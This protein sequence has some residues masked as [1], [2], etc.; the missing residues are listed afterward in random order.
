[1]RKPQLL[2][3]LAGPEIGGG[4]FLSDTRPEAKAAELRAVSDVHYKMRRAG[5]AEPNGREADPPG[6]HA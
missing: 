3:Y 6:R 2:K 5:P 1:L 4:N